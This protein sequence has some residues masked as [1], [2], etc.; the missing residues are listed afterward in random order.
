VFAF[1]ATPAK[2]VKAAAMVEDAAKTLSI[3]M[4]LGDPRPLPAAEIE[5]WWTRYH[6][7]YGQAT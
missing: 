5:K 1:D 3:A 4:P 2:A 7:T 6:E